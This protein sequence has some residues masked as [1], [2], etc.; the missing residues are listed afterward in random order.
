MNKGYGDGHQV[1]LNF[2]KAIKN[3]DAQ[4]FWSL[5]DKRGQGYFLGLWFYA[6]PGMDINTVE[7]LT[8]EE[9]FL[10]DA[11]GNIIMSL[12]NNLAQLLECPELGKIKY[13]DE[14]HATVPLI[15]AGKNDENESIPL[16]LELVSVASDTLEPKGDINFT[17]WKIDTLRCIKLKNESQ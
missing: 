1:V 13:I 16:V 10:Q 2:L 3:E 9:G 8:E 12:K 6:L 5:L 17:C 15:Q 7:R 14:H 4:V 11:L